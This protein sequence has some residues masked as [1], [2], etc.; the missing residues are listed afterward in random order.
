MQK[1]VKG[2]FWYGSYGIVIEVLG[3]DDE[4]DIMYCKENGRVQYLPLKSFLRSFIPKE[5]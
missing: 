3:V 5:G 1:V 4:G 2:S